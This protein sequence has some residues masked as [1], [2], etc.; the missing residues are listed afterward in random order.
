MC[1][2]VLEMARRERFPFSVLR[3][4]LERVGARRFQQAVSGGRPRGV[5]DDERRVDER[6][7]QFERGEFFGVRL[8]ADVECSVER[9][10]AR[11]DRDGAEET[12]PALVEQRVAPVERGGE[13]ALPRRI[14]VAA[15]AQQAKA[16]VEASRDVADR[17][18]ARLRRGEL[19]GQRDAVQPAADV[20]Y[21]RC[22]GVG[23]DKAG[24]DGPG[25]LNEQRDRGKR[26]RVGD[27]QLFVVVEERRRERRRPE[28]RLGGDREALPARRQDRKLGTRAQE[29]CG[30]PRGVL[31]EV[32][33][34]VEHEQHVGRSERQREHV[35]RVRVGAQ[36]DVPCGGDRAGDQRP[37]GEARKIAEER[38]VGVTRAGVPRGLER[39]G[40]LADAART[41]NGDE[42][43]RPERRI[44]FGDLARSA[45]DGPEGLRKIAVTCRGDGGA[46]RACRARRAG[47]FGAARVV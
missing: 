15:V 31:H 29:R 21:E 5:D 14:R 3:E 1:A 7:N 27:A 8:A 18:R 2:I 30:D 19:D 28:R 23:Q 16:L 36:P 34:V 6:G 35:G 47:K 4:F 24:V 20:R 9:E 38:A 26:Q 12:L 10:G 44:E 37:V 32:L 17:E 11:E 25:A 39:Q 13:R 46:R 33:A 43:V 22:V 40:G 45:D 42:A 41:E